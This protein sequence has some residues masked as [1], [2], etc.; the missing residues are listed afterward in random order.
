MTPEELDKVSELSEHAFA[1][2]EEDLKLYAA[3]ELRRAIEAGDT[4]AA[5]RITNELMA[6]AATH[7]KPITKAV[8]KSIMEAALSTIS[9]DNERYEAARIVGMI[10]DYETSLDDPIIRRILDDG[11]RSVRDITNLTGS[12]AAV[13]IGQTFADTLDQAMMDVV[14]GSSYDDAIKDAVGK[15]GKSTTMV[16]FTSDTGA[17]VKRSLYGIVRT[18]V[19]TGANQTCSR[20]QEARIKDMGAEYVETSAHSG[21]RPEHAVWQGKVF[22]YP[23]EFI[24]ATHYGEGSGL[25][26]WNCRHSFS[27]FF[28]GIMEPMDKSDIPSADDNARVYAA[29]QRQRECERNIRD[30]EMRASVYKE[31]GYPDEAA[32]CKRKVKE[33]QDRAQEAAD[34]V[35][36]KRDFARER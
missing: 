11:M 13:S 4:Q 2:L 30:Y 1:A 6:I 21:A 35:G 29:S 34:S 10:G 31:T 26:G 36:G 20:I 7:K 28:P 18:A 17:L 19:M 32:Y 16:S 3:R 9:A 5:N 24:A 27:P 8:S 33:W 22:R 15:I 25:G 14:T 23:D 12:K